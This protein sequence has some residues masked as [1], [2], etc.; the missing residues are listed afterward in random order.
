MMKKVLVQI[1]TVEPL[2]HTLLTLQQLDTLDIEV[3]YYL[4]RRLSRALGQEVAGTPEAG[5]VGRH[6][7]VFLH[8]ILRPLCGEAP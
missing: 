2:L 8:I 1:L 3:I 4:Y 7:T 6:S 5:L